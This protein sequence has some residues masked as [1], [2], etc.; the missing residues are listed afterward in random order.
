MKKISIKPVKK[1]KGTISLKGDKSISHRA[2]IV[3]SIS[4]GRSVIKNFLRSEDCLYTID[5]FRKLGINIDTSGDDVIVEGKGLSGLKKAK[6]DIYLGNSGTSMRLISGIAAGQNFE[7]TLTGDKS[8]S[9]RPMYRVIEPLRLM[10]A[11]IRGKEDK[12]A[13]LII[14]GGNLKAIKYKTKVASAQIKS[15]VLLAGLYA[16]GITEVLEPIKSRDHTERMLSLFGAKLVIEDLKVAI[17]NKPSLK[18]RD[19]TI[20]GDISSAA[21][22]ITAA[23]ILEGSQINI[24]NLVFNRTR[25]GFI[26]ALKEMGADINIE[27]NHFAGYE[28]VCDITV[29]SSRLKGITISEKSIP[30]LIDELPALMVAAIFAEGVTHIKGARELRVKETDRINSM[31]APLKEMG[32]EIVVKSDDIIIK[33]TGLLTGKSVDCRGD[34]RTAMSLAIAALR[35]KNNT[36]IRDVECI[37]TSF[38]DFFDTLNSLKV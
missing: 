1:L 35:A 26:D 11:D 13:P 32:A 5:A 30:S 23:L 18:A 37:N 29:K 15:A 3:A 22:F 19:L 4:E 21:F 33:G 6:E 28:D 9:N 14:K 38:P 20:P 36:E 12:F 10:G 8:L 16:D 34:H 7:T 27:N 25:L 31:T 24:K 17:N 2:I